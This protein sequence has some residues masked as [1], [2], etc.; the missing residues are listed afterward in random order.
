MFLGTDN[1]DDDDDVVLCNLPDEDIACSWD[2]G[3][4]STTELAQWPVHTRVDTDRHAGMQ[5]PTD[6]QTQSNIHFGGEA[7]AHCVW[8]LNGTS[9][10]EQR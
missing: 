1:D 6:P 2:W 7:W 10:L 3:R 9:V 5:R 8:K 4:A